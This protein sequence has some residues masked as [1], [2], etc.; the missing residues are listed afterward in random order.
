[1]V[2]EG[3]D[4]FEPIEIVQ[5]HLG[6]GKDWAYLSNAVGVLESPVF[7]DVSVRILNKHALNTRNILYINLKTALVFFRQFDIVLDLFH[8]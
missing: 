3:V 6:S 1:M 5:D 7:N 2:D 8:A 4:S